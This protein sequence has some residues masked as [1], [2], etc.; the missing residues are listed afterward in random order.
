MKSLK[1]KRIVVWVDEQGKADLQ[2]RSAESGS[3]VGEICR[4]ALR[5]ASFA[6]AQASRGM[7]KR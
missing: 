4:Q 7:E 3:T 1:N 5:L 6:D 2:R